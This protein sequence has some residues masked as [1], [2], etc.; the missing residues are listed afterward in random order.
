MVEPARRL[1]VKAEPVDSALR[2]KFLTE[3]H[4][5]VFW[6]DAVGEFADYVAAGLP[7]DLADVTIFEMAKA[8]RFYTTV[9]GFEPKFD[10]DMGEFRWI[11]VTAPEGAEGVE[12][13]LDPWDS[14]RRGCSSRPS[15]RLASPPPCS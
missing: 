11:T 12:L 9:L 14:R 10:I 6:H 2:Q 15:T 5:L 4:R 3:G 13:V 1:R 7:A 8:L